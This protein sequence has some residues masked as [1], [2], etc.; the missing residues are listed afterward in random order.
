ME[1]GVISRLLITFIYL[2]ICL[3]F[4]VVY[5]PQGDLRVTKMNKVPSL[6]FEGSVKIIH[7]ENTYKRKV[8]CGIIQVKPNF[9]KVLRS[10]LRKSGS[11]H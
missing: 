8:V 9:S 11:L 1:R 3:L 6:P 2:N 7:I 4:T 5:A 10:T